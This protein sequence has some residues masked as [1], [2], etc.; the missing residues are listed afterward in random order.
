MS[1]ALSLRPDK[2]ALNDLAR[3]TKPSP[4]SDHQH[5]ALL[6]NDVHP[7]DDQGQGSVPLSDG[8][9]VDVKV[10]SIAQSEPSTTH[11]DS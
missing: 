3:P 11:L 1:P 2:A 7:H 8:V 4:L 9:A 10:E 5:M 6:I